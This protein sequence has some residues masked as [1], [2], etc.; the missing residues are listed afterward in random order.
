MR[1]LEI[2]GDQQPPQHGLEQSFPA[3]FHFGSFLLDARRRASVRCD[4]PP[5]SG[6]P[7]VGL[8][9][10]HGRSWNGAQAS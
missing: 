2:R 7:E 1:G 6:P 4:V 10:E 3:A 9:Y 8:R 5:R